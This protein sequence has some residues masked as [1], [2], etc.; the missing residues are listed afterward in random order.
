MWNKTSISTKKDT[1]KKPHTQKT[2]TEQ[3]KNKKKT[4]PPQKKNTG[5]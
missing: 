5:V 2:K 4:D 3:I 1:E